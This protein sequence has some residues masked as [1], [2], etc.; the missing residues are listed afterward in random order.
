MTRVARRLRMERETAVGRAIGL[1]RK[2]YH[3]ERQR[4]VVNLPVGVVVLNSKLRARHSV[5]GGGLI[6]QRIRLD[7]LWANQISD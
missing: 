4:P 7:G 1:V 6:E 2:L 3:F 5:I